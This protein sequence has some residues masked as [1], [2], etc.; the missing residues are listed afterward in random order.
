MGLSLDQWVNVGAS[1]LVTVVCALF[2]V[3]YHLRTMWWRSEVGRNLMALAAALGA[4][5]LYTVL[6]TFWPDGSFAQVLRWVR[7]V[8]ALA[9]AA[10]MTQRISLL[11]KAQ[12]EHHNHD[13]TGV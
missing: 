6:L 5:F 9:I 12:R 2:V 4:L 10:V 8:V 3:I 11:L 1:M 13:R 7:A